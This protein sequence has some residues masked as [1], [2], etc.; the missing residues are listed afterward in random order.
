MTSLSYNLTSVLSF[1]GT[2]K[3]SSLDADSCMVVSSHLQVVQLDPAGPVPSLHTGKRTRITTTY[4][5]LLPQHCHRKVC[6]CSIEGSNWLPHICCWIVKL[7]RSQ[8]QTS[9]ISA[10]GHIDSLLAFKDTSMASMAVSPLYHTCFLHP[11]H[12]V[13][14]RQ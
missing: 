3:F 13:I 2:G 1:L 11:S 12:R 6:S 14:C 9:P 8:K 10:T 4:N 5:Q 7:C